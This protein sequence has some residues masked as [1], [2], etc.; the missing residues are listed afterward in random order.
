MG[1][2][3]PIQVNYIA[4]MLRIQGGEDFVTYNLELVTDRWAVDAPDGSGPLGNDA[5]MG[6]LNCSPNALPRLYAE[7]IF[8]F[9]GDRAEGTIWAIIAAP[10]EIHIWFRIDTEFGTIRQHSIATR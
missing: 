4:D 3:E 9:D 5:L 6:L 8:D 7:Q 1:G 2:P 10:D